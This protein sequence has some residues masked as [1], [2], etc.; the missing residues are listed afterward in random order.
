VVVVVID[1][2]GV[3]MVHEEGGM[4]TGARGRLAVCLRHALSPSPPSFLAPTADGVGFLVAA[5]VG[6]KRGSG[7]GM[8]EKMGKQVMYHGW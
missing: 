2:R 5:V 3:Y 4:L 6:R 8:V 1:L 7:K